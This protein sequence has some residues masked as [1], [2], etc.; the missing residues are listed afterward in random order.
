MGMSPTDYW[1]GDPC[2]VKAYRKAWELK[3]RE[4]NR[5]MW[6]QGLYI[7]EALCDVSP[8]LH[9]FAK[10]GTKPKEYLK[11]PIALTEK[12]VR[13]RKERDERERYEKLKAH[14][15]AWAAEHNNKSKEKKE[16]SENAG[17]SD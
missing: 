10:N 7:Y 6:L 3:A 8:I 1:E 16:V 17:H 11:E 14:V 5:E 15:L 12:E 2:L 9:A 4:R 13:E